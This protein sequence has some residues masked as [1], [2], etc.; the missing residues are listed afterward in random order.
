[1]TSNLVT[2]VIFPDETQSLCLLSMMLEWKWNAATFLLLNFIF[3]WSCILEKL[4][5]NDQIDA[6]LRFIQRK[7]A[8]SWSFTQRFILFLFFL[9]IIFPLN[10]FHSCTSKVRVLERAC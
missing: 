6:D 1:M 7:C 10:H 9:F 2:L 8:S 4:W 5:V 3:C